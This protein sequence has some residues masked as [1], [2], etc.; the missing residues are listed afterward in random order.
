MNL[1]ASA[2]PSTLF[3]ALSASAFGSTGVQ[4]RGIQPVTSN[5]GLI[6]NATFSNAS[7]SEF[8]MQTNKSI[9]YHCSAMMGDGTVS[10]RHAPAPYSPGALLLSWRS[11]REFGFDDVG[12]PDRSRRVMDL[13]DV[14]RVLREKHERFASKIETAEQLARHLNVVGVLKASVTDSARERSLGTSVINNVVGQRA[15]VVN[16]WGYDVSEGMRA[17]LVIRQKKTKTD[18]GKVATVWH[19]APYVG[20]TLPVDVLAYEVDDTDDI[21]DT[22]KKKTKIGHAIFVG[23]I[24]SAPTAHADGCAN[25]VDDPVRS[26][27]LACYAGGVEVCLGV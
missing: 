21:D 12:C 3:G 14:N 15:S 8:G 6:Q 17:Y 2:P 5:P 22:D 25:L 27:R 1:N 19:V 9:V 4:L 7:P 18:G 23:T 26:A 24:M 10:D 13:M 20:T 11:P 16:V